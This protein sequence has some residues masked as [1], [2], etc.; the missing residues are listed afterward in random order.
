M[1]SYFLL[2]SP[3]TSE[4]WWA[5]VGPS[6]LPVK[7]RSGLQATLATQGRETQHISP[8]RDSILEVRERPLS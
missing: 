7:L 8:I 2:L 3:F 5:R 6:H 1:R 4:S